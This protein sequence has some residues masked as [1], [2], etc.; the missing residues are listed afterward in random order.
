MPAEE[1]VQPKTCLIFTGGSGVP[2]LPLPRPDIV[3]AADSGAAEAIR[4]ALEI[5]LIVGDFDSASDREVAR[6]MDD[7]AEVER[8]PADKD[9]TDLEL[10]LLAAAR[11]GARRTVVVG[12]G[13]TDRI[14]HVL[15][16]AAVIAAE[17]HAAIAPEWWVGPAVVTPIRGT[18][19][20]DGRLG[21]T[22]SL[23]P[24]GGDVVVSAKGVRW[25][26]DRRVI[27]FGSS[28]GISNEIVEPDAAVEVHEGV[29]MAIEVRP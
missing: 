7:G 20:L 11:M 1:A 14:D 24:L 25:P 15:G 3:I 17:R 16:N 26:L 28:L 22:L 5:D 27:P 29:V 10:A 21:H 13:G 12:G 6:A 4:R 8:H 23:V 9:A 2:D 19:R 18:M